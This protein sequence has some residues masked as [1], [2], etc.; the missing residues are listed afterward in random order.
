[1]KRGVFL[2]NHR[3]ALP[4]DA[5]KQAVYFEKVNTEV[6]HAQVLTDLIHDLSI[7]EMRTALLSSQL[8]RNYA[9]LEQAKDSLQ[10]FKSTHEKKQ[11]AVA[12]ILNLEDAT[13]TLEPFGVCMFA[14]TQYRE[15]GGKKNR[16]FNSW[17]RNDRLQK[18]AVQSRVAA[19]AIIM[20]VE[21]IAR[22]AGVRELQA[23]TVKQS[24]EDPVVSAAAV[25]D[26]D[27]D[28]GYYNE[29]QVD[30]FVEGIPYLGRRYSK[31]L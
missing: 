24:A 3:E 14:F 23:H 8:K 21:H 17:Y 29:G 10:S 27:N 31:I 25:L 13:H 20:G 19:K 9:N 12:Y 15:P 30:I 6:D 4:S 26:M 7:G 16:V 11:S 18:R 5:A 28:F 2:N 22:Q 1:M